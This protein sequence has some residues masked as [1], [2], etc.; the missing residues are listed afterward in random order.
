MAS[1]FPSDYLRGTDNG[2]PKNIFRS[3]AII[4]KQFIQLG[5]GNK[6]VTCNKEMEVIRLFDEYIIG[7]VSCNSLCS[8][9]IQPKTRYVAICRN[10]KAHFDCKPNIVCKECIEKFELMQTRKWIK[11][12]VVKNYYQ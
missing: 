6:R 4:C 2:K 7:Y 8:E 12:E 9:Y 11:Y 10:Q 5:P 1:E 3:D